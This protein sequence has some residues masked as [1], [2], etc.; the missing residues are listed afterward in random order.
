MDADPGSSR[1]SSRKWRRLMVVGLFV[2]AALPFVRAAAWRPQGV[3]GARPSDGLHRVPGVVH[4]H[5]LLSDGGGTPEE[6]ARAAGRAG[7]KFVGITDHNHLAAKAFEG[8]HDGVL[9]LVGTE[10]S[11]SAGHMVALGLEDPGF[12]FSGDPLDALDDVHEL[13]GSV[14]AAHPAN[15]RSDFLWSGWELPGPWGFEV[16]N[17]D[18]QWRKAGAVQLG[19]TAALYLVNSRYALA[20]SLSPLDDTLRAWD[21]LLAERAVPG[22]AGADAHSYVPFGKSRGLR[23]PSYEALFSLAR[24][25]A[26][27]DEPLSGEAGP[28]ARRVVDALARGRCYVGLEALAPAGELSFVARTEEQT[29]TMGDVA[30]PDPG[31]RLVVE[32]RM[33]VGAEVS[34]LRDGAVLSA[35]RGGLEVEAPGA[36]VY[37]AE[38][39]LSGWAVPWMISNPIYVF[40]EA[41]ASAREERA[42]WPHEA[43]APEPRVWID[44]FDGPESAFHA[45][46]DPSS[47][48]NTT[49]VE[50]GAGRNG[51]G[52]ARLSFRLGQPGP[53]QPYTWCALVSR[54]ERDFSGFEGLTFWMRSDR[55]LRIWVQV[56]DLN[57]ASADEGTEWWFASARGGGEWR[58]VTLPFRRFRTANPHTD[59]R[60]D[61]D[62][63]RQVVFVLDEGAVAPG[64]TGTL[65]ID[66]L[67]LF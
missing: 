37:R 57:P 33:P 10:I 18:S 12:R 29:W 56:R 67:A 53:G 34:V 28:D 35:G 52:A 50:A 46:F 31:L 13:G 43:A 21:R 27:L 47:E 64:S 61:L 44:R 3:I 41:R 1:P 42:A 30:P 65:W 66:D 55:R 45:E 17:G 15:S 23:F 63:V 9:V 62:K 49:V 22:N 14:W 59:G 11:T 58:Q 19:T 32:G 5:T 2:L 25:Y 51:K 7:L 40:D 24:T 16:L 26:V 54:R 48:Q 36:G 60:L 6:V 39:R 38:V 4:V 20:R 8:Y